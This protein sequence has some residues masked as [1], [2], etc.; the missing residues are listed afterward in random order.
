MSRLPNTKKRS[1]ILCCKNVWIKWPGNVG[2]DS[3]GNTWG[4]DIDLRFS[5]HCKRTLSEVP[6]RWHLIL[7]LSQEDQNCIWGGWD[8]IFKRAFPGSLWNGHGVWQAR[9][10]LPAKNL[11]WLPASRSLLWSI[12]QLSLWPTVGVRCMQ[13]FLFSRISVSIE[14]LDR[15]VM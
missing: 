15:F 2:K 4:G 1:G 14:S 3:H 13:I 7:R 9:A 5:G 11:Q 12:P 6:R 10:T 8:A